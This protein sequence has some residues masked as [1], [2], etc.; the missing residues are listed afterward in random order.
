M[1]YFLNKGLYCFLAYSVVLLFGPQAPFTKN[2]TSQ[3]KGLSFILNL[4]FSGI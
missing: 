1:L 4:S 3:P 2:H